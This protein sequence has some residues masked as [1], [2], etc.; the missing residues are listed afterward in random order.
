MQEFYT[1]LSIISFANLVIKIQ[2][3][4]VHFGAEPI[5][6]LYGLL[7]AEMSDFEAKVCS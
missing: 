6:D 7:D 2:E 1:N 3:M 5:N 4:N